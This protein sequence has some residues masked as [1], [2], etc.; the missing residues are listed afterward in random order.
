MLTLWD[1]LDAICS[2]AGPDP[3]TAKYYDFDADYLL[4]RPK[5]A[6]HYVIAGEAR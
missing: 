4:E 3:E 1:S 5:R 2:F 6:T